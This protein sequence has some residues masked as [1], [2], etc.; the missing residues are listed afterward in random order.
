MEG[1]LLLVDDDPG[2]LELLNEYFAG[3][4]YSV[5][6]A[7]SGEAA[8]SAVRA[9]RPDLV[10]LDIR[11]LGIDGV[12]VLRRLRREDATLPVVMV[13]ANEDIT[14]A[15]ETLNAGAFDYVA[16]PFDF[17]HLEQ[18]VAAG[19]MHGAPSRNRADGADGAEAWT[20]VATAVFQ[21]TR[22]MPEAARRSTGTRLEDAVLG[23][24]RAS[25]AGRGDAARAA[26]GEL[27]LLLKLSVE[28]GD[29]PA[30]GR[31]AVVAALERVGGGA[32]AA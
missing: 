19:L 15:R 28:V 16:K 4:G 18:V 7:S 27:R 13:T 6:L 24:A 30:A 1:R 31:D 23:A 8:L 10:L 32:P 25:F 26:L 5:E 11:M 20:A 9:K 12:E 21:A 14:L 3:Q 17:T 29:L 2:V 22:H